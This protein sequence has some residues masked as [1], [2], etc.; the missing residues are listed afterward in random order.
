MAIG[1][2]PQR[3]SPMLCAGRLRH[4]IDLV[5]PSA[6]QDST[7]GVIPG[8]SVVFAEVWASV[9]AIGGTEQASAG[10]FTSVVTHQVT[11]RYIGNSPSWQAVWNYSAQFTVIDSN[12]N[13]QQ[14]Q[15]AGLSGATAPTWNVTPGGTTSDGAP[16]TGV[17]WLNLGAPVYDFT[18]VT[19]AMRVKFQNRTFQILDV[20]NPDERTKMLILMCT[21]IN[22]SRQ[23]Q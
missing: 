3:V 9:E 17:T 14:A 15:G 6:V 13:V 10:S 7:G 22:D 11:I 8:Q 19:A 23:Q 5:L 12:G 16:S 1:R 20:L 18:A 4:I 21:E 2:I